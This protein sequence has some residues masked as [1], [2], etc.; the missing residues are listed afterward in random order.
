MKDFSKHDQIVSRVL[1]GT[2]E[3]S[4]AFRDREPI[5]WAVAYWTLGAE[6][7]SPQ[8]LIEER[9]STMQGANLRHLTKAFFNLGQANA[10]DA[11]AF[12]AQYPNTAQGLFDELSKSW[13][14]EQRQGSMLAATRLYDLISAVCPPS[15]KA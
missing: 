7:P 9:A 3:E 14:N 4:A 6:F 2:P 12:A 10:V 1:G 11:L 5:Q 8:C 13:T 15:P